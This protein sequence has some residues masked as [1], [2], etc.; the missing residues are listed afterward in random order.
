MP[1]VAL[2]F[3]YLALILF[4]VGTIKMQLPSGREINWVSAGL[5]LVTIAW[6][7]GRG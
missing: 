4:L 7:V 6:L 2:V 5:A 1:T 3:V